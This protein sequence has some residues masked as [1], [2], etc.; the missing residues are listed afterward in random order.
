MASGA[1]DAGARFQ[2]T[3][4]H[5]QMLLDL[6]PAAHHQTTYTSCVHMRL[7]MAPGAEDAGSRFQETS[8]HLQMLLELGLAPPGSLHGKLSSPLGP[9]FS[10]S[11][12]L[13][14]MT[15]SQELLAPLWPSGP[16][17]SGL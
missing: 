10:G 9:L 12:P 8:S 11:M 7:T 15:S 1:E 4:S 13:G 14:G 2:E 17:K 6:V 16:I 5:L 3:S